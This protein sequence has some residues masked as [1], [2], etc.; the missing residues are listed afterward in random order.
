[1]FEEAHAHSLTDTP[2]TRVPGTRAR[3]ASQ[4]TA[5]HQQEPLLVLL[6]NGIYLIRWDLCIH[7]CNNAARMIWGDSAFH[8]TYTCAMHTLCMCISYIYL[9]SS[10]TGAH[11][12]FLRRTIVWCTSIFHRNLIHSHAHNNSRAPTIPFNYEKNNNN[13]KCVHIT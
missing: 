8:F 2:D 9:S 6:Y 13:T 4:T 7:A 3:G 10:S 5:G 12:T 1:M 11:V